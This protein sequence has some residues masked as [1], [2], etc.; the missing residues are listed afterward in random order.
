[1]HLACWHGH[2]TL[3]PLLLEHKADVDLQDFEGNT[4][5]HYACWNGNLEICQALL[6]AGATVDIP[7]QA[8]R[9]PLYFSVQH[10]H[11]DIVKFL[12]EN[13]SDPTTQTC[14]GVTPESLA[15]QENIDT[16]VEIFQKFNKELHEKSQNNDA[17]NDGNG[18]DTNR[19]NDSSE[20]LLGKDFTDE[21]NRMKAVINK[22][23][24][25]RD[26]EIDTL[27][28][29]HACLDEHNAA[30]ST[31]QSNIKGTMNQLKEIE[32][33]LRGIIFNINTINGSNDVSIP[34]NSTSSFVITKQNMPQ[35]PASTNGT[36]Y[37]SG[38]SPYF[39]FASL[40]NT[41]GSSI[42]SNNTNVG[43]SPLL[44]N[45]AERK[46]NNTDQ[47]KSY[48]ANPNN[49]G[50]DSSLKLC[51]L[52]GINPATVRCKNCRSPFCNNCIP[53]V[54]A[55]GCKFCKEIA[56]AKAAKAEKS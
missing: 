4:P 14:T 20:N 22:L 53:K 54:R 23:I 10:K 1:M 26:N 17:T 18:P 24:E 15:T 50:H 55:N 34:T 29:L 28:R 19:N 46:T 39:A 9:T 25:G 51:R 13:N 32:Y 37:P 40:N 43:T 21:H 30:I 6:K 16:I 38:Y 27:Q 41:S 42:G 35:M 56:A 8:G 5:L 48:Y 12:L 36:A 11:P 45:H 31:I 7:D 47:T 49:A 2:V 52:C 33:T 3:I 44:V